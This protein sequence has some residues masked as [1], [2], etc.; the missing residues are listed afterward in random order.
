M[1]WLGAFFGLIGA[2]LLALNRD[3]SRLGWWA[4]VVANLC[5][6]GFAVSVNAYGLLTQQLGFTITSCLG[7][8]RSYGVPWR[9]K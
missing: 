7:I 5:W 1:E 8:W 9:Q 6:I 2:F 3:Y 4:F